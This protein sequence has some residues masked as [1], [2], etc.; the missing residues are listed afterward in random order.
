MQTCSAALTCCL[1]KILSLP[2]RSPLAAEHSL[3]GVGTA[4]QHHGKELSYNNYLDA[5]AAYST[6]KFWAS[7][8]FVVGAI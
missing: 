6:G 3:G 7:A 1:Q 8:V 5:D 4:V 2:T